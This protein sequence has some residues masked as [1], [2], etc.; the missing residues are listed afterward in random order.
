MRGRPARAGRAGAARAA[1]LCVVEGKRAEGLIAERRRSEGLMAQWWGTAVGGNGDEELF[2]PV[3]TLSGDAYAMGYQHGSRV[4]QRVRLTVQTL[5]DA[6]GGQVF[7]AGWHAFQP[8]V[9]YCRAE[10]PELVAEMEGIADGA[11][12]PFK[13][14]WNINAHLD[15][16]VWNRTAEASQ[17]L[18]E[19]PGCSSH[20][21]VSQGSS[22][23]G[24]N[25]DD[26]SAWMNTGVVVRG[27]PDDGRPPFVYFSWAGT[28]GRP[29]LSHALAVG[30]NSVPPTAG[31]RSDGLLY[32]MVCRKL[33][34]CRSTQDAIATMD[35]IHT[36]SAMNYMLADKSGEVADIETNGRELRVLRPDR[37]SNHLLHTNHYLHPDHEQSNASDAPCPR[38][39]T[40]REMYARS[41]PQNV[42]SIFE[43]LSTEPVYQSPR[44]PGNVQHSETVVSMVAQLADERSGE[45]AL[46]VARGRAGD[47]P[48]VRVAVPSVAAPLPLSPTSFAALSGPSAGSRPAS[49]DTIAAAGITAE[50]Q[51]AFERD[52]FLL[53]RGFYSTSEVE[54]L[55]AEFHDMVTNR[56][57]RPKKVSYGIMAP[58]PGFSPD[59]FNPLNVEGMMD[60]TL[61]SPYWFD[62]FAE[63]RLVRAMSQ[64]LG[65]DLDF[66][67]GKVRNKPPGYEAFQSWHQDW[68]CA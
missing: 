25:G 32:N 41:L 43:V 36:C 6:V 16:F 37:G 34:E 22:L 55:R 64:L 61:V 54:T 26:L 28:I 60:Q 35:R 50:Q 46:F 14:I 59:P 13:D 1:G 15:L 52:G 53:L 62:Q 17:Q 27:S 57:N 23:L 67:N 30:A 66:H 65:A 38:L 39:Q 12:V 51:A 19:L 40:A 3:L 10:V 9:E 68:P 56:D 8:T 21:V 24:W 48:V 20:A 11:A 42:D 31:H 5:R 2:Y 4:S 45:A 18:Q 44:R 63:P 7:D 47:V 49:A 33:L 58:K 29:G